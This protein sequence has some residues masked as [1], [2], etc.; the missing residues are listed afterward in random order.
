MVKLA[1][2]LPLMALAACVTNQGAPIKATNFF[3]FGGR[4]DDDFFVARVGIN[5][6]FGS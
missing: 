3:G 5:Y 4:N 1:G 6:K 2:W